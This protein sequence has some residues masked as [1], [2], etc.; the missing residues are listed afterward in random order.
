MGDT[1][2]AL[3]EEAGLQLIQDTE[4]EGGTRQVESF[5]FLKALHR[6]VVYCIMYMYNLSVVIRSTTR[7]L[8]VIY[9]YC[10]SQIPIHYIWIWIQKFASIGI[11]SEAFHT[12]TTYDYLVIY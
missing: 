9:P 1:Q 7:P 10:K 4:T 5:R 3:R 2:Q 6:L 12:I 8:Q 11:E